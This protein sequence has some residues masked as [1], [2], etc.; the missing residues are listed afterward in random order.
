MKISGADSVLIRHQIDRAC[1]RLYHCH[2][3]SLVNYARQRGCDEHEAWD[4][5][6]DLF[7]RLF[8]REMI[9]PLAG[10]SPEIQRSFLLRTLKWMVFNRHRHKVAEKRFR[11]AAPESLNVMLDQ[12]IEIAHAETPE[13]EIDRAWAVS[14]VDRCLLRLRSCV[15]PSTWNTVEDSITGRKEPGEPLRTTSAHRVATHRAKTRLKQFI[16]SEI[17]AGTNI[18]EASHILFQAVS[19][20]Q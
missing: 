16:T 19:P 3:V 12:G 10:K 13:F 7:L 9:L 8:R 15:K 4:L 17:G 14:L 5:V 1:D 20:R 2:Q 11:G 18:R 6:Q